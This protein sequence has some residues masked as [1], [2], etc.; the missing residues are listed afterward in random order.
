MLRDDETFDGEDDEDDERE[1]SGTGMERVGEDF[2]IEDPP[3][4]D[5]I[6][7]GFCCPW[8]IGDD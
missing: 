4:T 8:T 1:E 6:A 2:L 7:I 5:G 3:E